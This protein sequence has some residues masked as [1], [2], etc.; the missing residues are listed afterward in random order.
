MKSFSPIAVLVLGLLLAL[1]ALGVQ[2]L[3]PG[4]WPDLVG[5]RAAEE[6]YACP[7]AQDAEVR[8]DKPG[9]CPKCGM[10]LVPI[11]QTEHKG[12]KPGGPAD[13]APSKAPA[14]KA[15]HAGHASPLP[16]PVPQGKG[17][18][19]YHCPMD[20]FTS[21]RP[22]DCPI[23]NMR[24]EPM[25]E[26]D[27]VAP[28]SI[29]GMAIVRLGPERMQLIGVRVGPVA[30]KQVSRTIR[31]AGRV[32]YDEKKLSAVSLKFGGWIEELYLKATGDSVKRGDPLFAIYS[33]ELLE[34][35]RNYLLALEAAKAP[36][37]AAAG[38]GSSLEANL[39]SARERLLLW[40]IGEDQLREIESKGEPRTRLVVRS[41][42]EGVVTERNVV[43]GAF[44]EPGKDLYRI[45]DLS[46]VWINAA[47]Y[48]SEIPLVNAGMEAKV[49]LSS[50]RED[51]PAGKVVFIYP[52]LDAET[53]T[54]RARLEFENRD[55]K[56]KPGMYATVSIESPLGERLVV[57]DGAVLDS[58]A[59]Q[60]AFVEIEEGRFEPRLV[61]LGP[62]A[63]GLVVVLEGLREGE[64]VATSGTFLIDSESRLKSALLRGAPDGG[65]KH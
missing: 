33:P 32:D 16:P 55:G 24:L 52:Y 28:S 21:D 48:E 19:I 3:H 38:L 2:F 6:V 17:K 22:G 56:L 47:I 62:R 11:S 45:A 7:M 49:H 63:D 20:G 65:H 30:R 57:D 13:P 18:Q 41:K 15:E 39:R 59:R 64:K 26:D 25:K 43:Q 29:E 40:D 1:G 50:V 8:S 54:V 31:A 61:K 27:S 36:G 42:V 60:I 5:A 53:R 58:G 37:G 14:G 23:C 12:K 35:Q 10:D 51:L 4:G 9:K 44:A 46:I 34:A